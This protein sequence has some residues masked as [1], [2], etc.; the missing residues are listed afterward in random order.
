[1]AYTLRMTALAVLGLML[2]IG[3]S[4]ARYDRGPLERQR[5]FPLPA[6]AHL[7]PHACLRSEV[8]W[9]GFADDSCTPG[10]ETYLSCGEENV[11]QHVDA[12]ESTTQTCGTGH[13]T[14]SL[15]RG[16]EEC[17]GDLDYTTSVPMVG[18]DQPRC[19]RA[20]CWC[21]FSVSH[22][23]ISLY[24]RVAPE[25]LHGPGRGYRPWQALLPYVFDSGQLPP[26][27]IPHSLSPPA[28][29]VTTCTGDQ[30]EASDEVI[31]ELDPAMD[32]TL[33]EPADG[34]EDHIG[35]GK[36]D[37]LFVGLTNNG[38]RRRILIQFDMTPVDEANIE[39]ISA[40]LTLT[41]AERDTSLILRRAEKNWTEGSNDVASNSNGGNGAVATDGATWFY[42]MLEAN[43]TWTNEGGDYY[44][45]TTST[46]DVQAEG[47]VTFEDVHNDVRHMMS[48]PNYGWLIVGDEANPQTTLRLPSRE[49][50]T[51]GLRPKL[52]VIGRLTNA[53]STPAPGKTRYVRIVI[54][55]TSGM[56]LSANLIRQAIVNELNEREI[57]VEELD[58][59]VVR[60]QSRRR[61]TASW[62]IFVRLLSSTT[63]KATGDA[64]V[65]MTEDGSL[66]G[67]I[68]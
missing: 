22:D 15:Y 8:C 40:H 31:L 17:M 2:T 20:P 64:L 10:T 26:C 3:Q 19:L 53:A 1:M 37:S 63:V 47:N 23:I 41:G 35:A 29:L 43:E 11:C 24:T 36:C 51:D 59:V 60:A 55:F 27:S 50:D 42:T 28:L 61:E 67:N 25:Y 39:V 38:Y 5:T 9:Q 48:N 33:Y 34:E 13:V 7:H 16:S 62:V 52:T 6:K 46:A 45:L 54:K 44:A 4:A 56:E 49:H 66:A 65:G 32:A 68:E 57:R 30:D 14:I 18:G 12:N 21:T 58:V